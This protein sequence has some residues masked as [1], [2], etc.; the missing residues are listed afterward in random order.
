MK[1]VDIKFR[2]FLC[3]LFFYFWRNIM[4]WMSMVTYKEQGHDVFIYLS[5][6]IIWGLCLSYIF[7]YRYLIDKSSIHKISFAWFIAMFVVLAYNRDPL[8]AYFKCLLWPLVFESVYIC[9]QVY[10]NIGKYFRYL[11]TALVIM[12]AM[13]FFEAM[14]FMGFEGASNMVYFVIL[15]VP[16]L[17]STGN[18]KSNML[19]LIIATGLALLSLKRS[20]ILAFILFWAIHYLVAIVQKGKIIQAVL[21]GSLFAFAG[22]SVYQYV[23][24]FSGGNISKR[25]EKEDV[26]NGRD[27]IYESTL[28]MIQNTTI[29][30]KILGNGHNGVKQDSILDIS[31]HNEWLEVIY[32]YGYIV[33]LVY[34]LLWIYMIRKWITL[35]KTRSEYFD[36][37]S[38]CIC[39]WAV[40]SMVSQLI[41]YVSYVIYLF[42]FLAYIESRTRKNHSLCI[43]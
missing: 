31:A 28:L 16:F 2:I 37:Y 41:L 21:V 20:M 27:A 9:S 13:Y 33:L 22:M 8:S 11:F 36:A 4:F 30:H 40:M 35:Y 34:A 25:M 19:Y 43:S 5:L 1:N 29:D 6:T 38:L 42:M 26:T 15:A 14:I 7:S 12:G 17:I 3:I 24:D 39:I 32:D 23:D 18:Q 10:N